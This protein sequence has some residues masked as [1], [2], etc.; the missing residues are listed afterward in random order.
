MIRHS[1]DV[2]KNAVEHLNPGQTPVVT[3]DQPLFALAKRIQW[4]WPE[5]YD[6]DKLVAMFGRLHIDMA[7]PKTPGDRLQESGWVHVLVQAEI[8]TSGIADSLRAAYVAR[9]RRA[10]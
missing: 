2:V 6:E 1:L 9:T 7:A 4:K 10:H 3:F 5:S 8:T